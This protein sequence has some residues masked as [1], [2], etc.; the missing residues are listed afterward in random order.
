[1]AMFSTEYPS[2]V[3]VPVVTVLIRLRAGMSASIRLS[4]M[5]CLISDFLASK[6]SRLCTAA[7]M[8]SQSALPCSRVSCFENEVSLS[9]YSLLI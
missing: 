7:R 2:R 9:M 4:S 1:M 6:S 5:R 3:R 8:S